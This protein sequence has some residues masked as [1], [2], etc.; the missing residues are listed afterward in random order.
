MT[1]VYLFIVF[2][3]P[4]DNNY[5]GLDYISKSTPEVRGIRLVYIA[6]LYIQ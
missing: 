3:N 1:P 6:S 2:E 5:Q 4:H